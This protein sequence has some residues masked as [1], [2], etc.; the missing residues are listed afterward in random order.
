MIASQFYLYSFAFILTYHIFIG[1]KDA[2][3]DHLG[4]IVDRIIIE[5]FRRNFYRERIIG[6]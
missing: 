2:A 3:V 4:R 5:L 1:S 6:E